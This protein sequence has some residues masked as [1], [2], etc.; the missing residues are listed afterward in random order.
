MPSDDDIQ[1]YIDGRL[2]PEAHAAVA[3]EVR[4]RRD[5]AARVDRLRRHHEAL[6]VIGRELLD[7][8]IPA[9]LRR[10][11][12]QAAPAQGRNTPPP[13]ASRPISTRSDMAQDVPGGERP[14]RRG[15]VVVKR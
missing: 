12:A 11:V 10:A 3:R 9:R 14:R 13:A 5:L 7:E 2:G 6:R 15:R 8:P 1:D 4:A